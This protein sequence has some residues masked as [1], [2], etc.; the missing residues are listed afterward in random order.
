MKSKKISRDIPPWFDLKKY[1]IVRSFGAFEWACN[2]DIRNTILR[3]ELNNEHAVALRDLIKK[4]GAIPKNVCDEYV[5]GEME[6]FQEQGWTGELVYD[7]PIHRA[8]QIYEWIKWD[9]LLQYNLAVIKYQHILNRERSWPLDEFEEKISDWHKSIFLRGSYDNFYDEYGDFSPHICVE[10]E[11]PDDVL[12]D[13]F[14]AWLHSQR[15]KD[16]LQ[17]LSIN[18]GRKRGK[19]NFDKWIDYSVLPYLDLKMHE[20]EISSKLTL[21]AIGDAIFGLE[22]EFDTTEAVRKTTS[23]YASEAL[24]AKNSLGAHGYYEKARR[25]EKN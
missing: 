20:V 22:V 9:T 5:R 23:V 11:A 2:L 1:D 15:Q 24:A 13:A 14:K 25:Q 21:H 18:A 12:V 3:S 17:K 10:L 19:W 8:H 16:E 7:L 6:I 4:Y